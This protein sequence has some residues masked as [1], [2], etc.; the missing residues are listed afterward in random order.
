MSPHDARRF[1]RIIPSPF[2]ERR[3]AKVLVSSLLIGSIHTVRMRGRKRRKRCNTDK[4][5]H[6]YQREVY[7]RWIDRRMKVEMEDGCIGGR[8]SRWNLIIFVFFG[9]NSADRMRGEEGTREERARCNGNDNERPETRGSVGT[10]YPSRNGTRHP[11]SE[12][13]KESRHSPS[14]LLSLSF[15][16][17]TLYRNSLFLF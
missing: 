3:S 12:N 15:F 17:H 1:S 11:C 8:Q 6:S 7:N 4:Q 14:P 10:R 2:F 16:S 5:D 9:D 13:H